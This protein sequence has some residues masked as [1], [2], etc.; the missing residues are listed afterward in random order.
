MNTKRDEDILIVEL[1]GVLDSHTAADFKV[2]LEEKLLQG[3]RAFALDCRN[4]KYLSSKGIGAIL[5]IHNLAVMKNA[6]FVLFRVS[7][8]VKRLLEFLKVTDEVRVFERFDDALPVLSE[9]P[10]ID[11]QKTEQ[12]EINFPSEADLEEEVSEVIKSDE[13]QYQPRQ[14]KVEVSRASSVYNPKSTKENSSS[15]SVEEEKKIVNKNNS[16]ENLTVNETQVNKSVEID[17]EQDNQDL[18]LTSHIDSEITEIPHNVEAVKEK[19]NL[20]IPSLMTLKVV[21]CPNCNIQLRVSKPGKYLCPTCRVKF[22][23]P[24]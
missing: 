11:N 24:F 7:N 6:A 15:D 23:Y 13:D 4:L 18:D 16:I 8:E 10:V 3:L 19:E 5:E 12:S 20:D 9:F 21:P 2:W 14:T 22:Q 1:D 17:N